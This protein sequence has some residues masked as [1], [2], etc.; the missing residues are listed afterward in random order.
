[1]TPKEIEALSVE[2]MH[3]I[4]FNELCDVSGCISR[5]KGS[6]YCTKH[7]KR[8]YETGKTALAVQSYKEYHKDLTLAAVNES[9][10]TTV[11]I[12]NIL[13]RSDNCTR[14]HLYTLKAE[15]K[16][17]FMKLNAKNFAWRLTASK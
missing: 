3:I 6:A 8:Y 7:E 16:V 1:M 14:G 10:Q 12:A 2:Q 5:R 15:G 9:W 4:L 11:A 17:D 13:K